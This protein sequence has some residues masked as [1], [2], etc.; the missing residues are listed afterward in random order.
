MI[1]PEASAIQDPVV[2]SLHDAIRRAAIQI[3][4]RTSATNGLRG[5]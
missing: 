3:L 5:C 1:E 4:P 2:V